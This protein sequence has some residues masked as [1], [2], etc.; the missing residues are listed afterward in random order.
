M[1]YGQFQQWLHE[2]AEDLV[3]FGVPRGEAEELIHALEFGAIAAEATARSED[4][5]LLDFK[6]VGS[7]G[8]AERLGVSPGAVRARR[9]ALLKKRTPLLSALTTAA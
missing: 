3:G 2:R 8:M 6:R 9:N 4:Q 1:N 7:V 5:F